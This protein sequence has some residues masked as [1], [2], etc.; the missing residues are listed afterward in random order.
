MVVPPADTPLMDSIAGPRSRGEDGFTIIESLVAMTVLLILA[1]AF[2][3]LM[4]TTLRTARANHAAQVA[5]GI[6]VEHLERT[7][8][9]T[10][11]QLAMPSVNDEAPMIDLST[12]SLDAEEVGLDADEAL[13][14]EPIGVVD[15]RVVEE[16]DG[17]TYT[18]WRYV[19]EAGP[20]LRRVTV[21]VTW[22]FGEMP[23]TRLT[24]TLVSEVATR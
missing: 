2:A 14:V 13:V 19:S 3:G 11:A 4:A 5:T 18:V 20:G 7:R 8:A 10:W 24:S 12:R 23:W 22:T 1:G 15:P 9:S 16:V 6:G 21:L 17:V